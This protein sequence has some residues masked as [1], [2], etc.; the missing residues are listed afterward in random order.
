MDRPG[1]R[2]LRQVARFPV[3]IHIVAE[4][5]LV[6]EDPELLVLCIADILR[7]N[8]LHIPV[9]NTLLVMDQARV[10]LALG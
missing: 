3:G 1:Y 9:S 8:D 7:E 4:V 2:H 5:V 10:R 6:Y